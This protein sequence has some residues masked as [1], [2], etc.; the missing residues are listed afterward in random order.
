MVTF[1]CQNC[2]QS[3][4]E[5]HRVGILN[6]EQV[7]LCAECYKQAQPL[8]KK[9]FYFQVQ[10]EYKQWYLIGKVYDTPANAAKTFEN[11]Y[12]YKELVADTQELWRVLSIPSKNRKL[13]AGK[14]KQYTGQ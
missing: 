13:S 8:E 11:F 5:L 12:I 9:W 1:I 10:N 14:V 2:S 6:G 4:G 3:A 7:C